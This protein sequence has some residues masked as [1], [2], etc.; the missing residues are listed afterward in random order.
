[1]TVS[2]HGTKVVNLREL[3]SVAGS[4]GGVRVTWEAPEGAL[5]VNAGLEDQATGY[6]ARLPLHFP[7]VAS[8]ETARLRYAAVGLMS[9]AADPMMLFPAGTTFTPYA[10][11]R[12]ISAPPLSVTPTLWW[13]EGS[14]PHSAKLQ[15]LSLPPYN[16]RN[17]NLPE[18]I[19]KAGLKNFNGSFNLIL[20]ADGKSRSL[21]TAVGSVDQR[22]TYVFEVLSSGVIESAA[23][24]LSY[25]S[26]RDGDDTMVTLWNPADEAQDFVFTLFFPGG[27]YR[28]P[29]HL[30]GRVTR[31]FNVSEIIHNQI[32]DDE[33]NIIPATAREG[34]AQIAGSN[35]DNE[36]I[37][38]S[39][40]VGTY[41]VQKA[42]C[43]NY[44][45]TCQGA[46]NAF[47]TDNPFG[48][49]V[50]GTHQLTMTVQY[51]NG[52]TYNHTSVATW[53]SSNTTLAT[54]S[55]GLVS[56]VSAGAISMDAFSPNVPD[57]AQGCLGYNPDGFC[58]Q[59][60]GADASDQG[61]TV[62]PSVSCPAVTRGQSVTCTASPGSTA[63]FTTNSWKFTD[64]NNNNVTVTG[65]NTGSTWS[66]A[67]AENGTVS[68]NVNVNGTNYPVQNNLT[69]NARTNFAFSA[70]AP[71]QRTNP[72]SGACSISVPTSPA[73]GNNVGF[74]C[75]DQQFFETPFLIGDNG[76]NQGFRYV[77]SASNTSN[78]VPTTFNFIIAGYLDDSTSEFAQKQC[79]NYN[80]TTNTGFI[81]YAQLKSNTYGHESGNTTG[82]YA[83]YKST[84]D[85][86]ANNI[87][88]AAEAVV[89][90]PGQSEADFNT[91]VL[92]VARAKGSTIVS[93]AFPTPEPFCNSDVRYDPSCVFRGFINWPVYATCP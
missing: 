45:F 58:P 70:V 88:T 7:P 22:N 12:N 27:H 73:A 43:G 48:V 87:G 79:G 4:Q 85:N 29:I 40:D 34:S 52:A 18:L 63:T 21:L 41:N 80:S 77:Y 49:L 91:Q 51:H 6:S 61:D 39:V 64:A 9:G 89:G 67:A 53:T 16:S 42:T 14:M 15:Q 24:S 76:P 37:L 25:W 23:K 26:T 32:P 92:N 57:F 36:L 54:V 59:S 60:T 31:T 78:N 44:C 10:L 33:G 56:G 68:V 20:D 65:T 66:G 75:L 13:M 69:I 30:D 84:Q 8:A 83:T 47:I 50:N 35:G 5:I 71:T 11:V 17:L 1:V 19:S 81:A 3:M 74:S 46:V 72:Y 38:V 82:H 93:A 28:L 86:A 2:P 62:N 90:P 55:S